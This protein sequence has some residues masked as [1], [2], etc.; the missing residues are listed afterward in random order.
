VSVSETSEKPANSR[1]PYTLHRLAPGSYDIDLDGRTIGCLVRA[2]AGWIAELLASDGRATPPPFTETEHS[3]P[4]L[5]DALKWLG[6]P[7]R[8]DR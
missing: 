7:P 4:K 1:T 5:V 8:E 6:M 2:E 3:F